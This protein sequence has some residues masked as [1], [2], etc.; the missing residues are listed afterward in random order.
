MAPVEQRK[1]PGRPSATPIQAITANA[2][3]KTIA[4]INS[5]LIELTPE[6]LSP[7]VN[8][9][10]VVS[11]TGDAVTEYPLR[12]LLKPHRDGGYVLFTVNMDNTVIT[13]NFIFPNALSSAEP[14][15]ENRSAF[16]LGEDK[17]SFVIAYEPFEVHVVRID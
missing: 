12:T 8:L 16:S 9:D 6:I 11:F 17:R 13:G 7:T 2:L 5:E 10:Y 15:F 14:M 4:V 3:W 1:I